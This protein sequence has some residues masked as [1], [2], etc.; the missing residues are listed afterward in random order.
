MAD[1]NEY[2]HF[3]GG[4]PELNEYDDLL[5]QDGKA[6][7]AQL[8]ASMQQA[9]K[10]N[11]DQQAKVLDLSQRTGLPADTVE[12]NQPE[13]EAKAKFEGNDYDKLL[14]DNP[15]LSQHLADRAFASVASDDIENLA[16]VE[17]GFAER[18][19]RNVAARIDTLGANLLDTLQQGQDLLKPISPNVGALVWDDGVIPRY[20]PPSE[21]DQDNSRGVFGALADM[22]HAEAEA[23]EVEQGH[24][25]ETVKQE[26]STGDYTGGMGEVF[27]YAAEQGIV[28][29]PDM[30]GALMSLPVYITSRANEIGDER[31]T[32]KGKE[33]SNILDTLEALPFA[34]GSAM[35]ERIGAG[36]ITGAGKDVAENLGKEALK[37]VIKRASKEGV[38]AGGKEALTEFLQEGIAEYTG[39][40]LGTGAELDIAEAAERGIAGAVAGGVYG[41]VTGGTVAAGRELERAV[42]TQSQFNSIIEAS[43][44][45]ALR[46]RSP[47]LFKQYL[48][49]LAEKSDMDG[50]FI[51]IGKFDELF[52][53][54]EQTAEEVAEQLGVLDEYRE[55]SITSTD[56][57]VPIE[58]YAAEIAPDYHS[59]LAN[60]IKV[61][62]D[63][64]SVS[65]AEAAAQEAEERAQADIERAVAEIESGSSAEAAYSQVLEDIRGQLLGLPQFT[66]QDAVVEAQATQ[67]ASVF[68]TLAQRSN[69]GKPESEH[70][71]AVDLFRRFPVEVQGDIPAILKLTEDRIDEL[72]L[73]LDALENGNLPTDLEVYG[74]SLVEFLRERG[75]VDD[76]GELGSMDADKGLAPFQR[77]LI[78]EE[79]V[80]LDDAALFATEAGYFP[81]LGTDGRADINQLLEAVDAE[82]RG[83]PVYNEQNLDPNLLNRRQ[84]IEQLDE[85]LNRAGLDPAVVDRDQ[86]KG[87]IRGDIS[88]NIASNAESSGLLAQ[89]GQTIR[90][91]FQGRN[92]DNSSTSDLDLNQEFREF[93]RQVQGNEQSTEHQAAEQEILARIV[94][95]WDSIGLQS[96]GGNRLVEQEWASSARYENELGSESAFGK[97]EKVGRAEQEKLIAAAKENNFFLDNDNPLFDGLFAYDNKGGEEHD[98][99]IV[100]EADGKQLV[101]RS[102]NENRF[103]HTSKH[104]PA[105]YLKRLE[106]YNQ[107]FPELQM[108]MIGVRE[109]EDGTAEI[110]TAQQFVKGEEFT[111]QTELDAAMRNEGWFEVGANSH[112]YQHKDTGSVIEDV[113]VG[114]VLHRDGQLYPIDVY[115]AKMPEI[116]ELYQSDAAQPKKLKSES[117]IDKVASG[118]PVTFNFQHNTDSASKHFG[119]PKKGDPFKREFE[120]SGRYVTV[121]SE[122]Q[123]G[124]LPDGFIS[125]EITLNNPLVVRNSG[126]QWK[127]NLSEQYG[128]KTGKELS[129]ALISDGYDGVITTEDGKYISEIVEFTSFDEAKALFQPGDLASSGKRGAILVPKT[130]GEGSASIIK[131][132]QSA[133]LS[134]FLHESGHLYLEMM[135][136]LSSDTDAP[137]GLLN[138]AQAILDWMGLESFDQVKTEHHEMWA[139]TYEQYL[140]E[141]KAP[142]T[143]LARA[144]EKFSAWLK[145]I[146]QQIKKNNLFN[147]NLTPEIRDVMDRLIATDEEIEHARQRNAINPDLLQTD[148][149][150]DKEKEQYIKVWQEAKE[151]DEAKLRNRVM[152]E[153][154][155]QRKKWWQEERER[156]RTEVADQV[157]SRPIYQ[158]LHYLQHKEL[159]NSQLPDDVEV[160]RLSK[161]ILV[162]QWGEEVLKRLPRPYVY[163]RDG[164]VHPDVVAD[165]FGFSSGD[166]LI[167]EL[168]NVRPRQKLINAETDQRMLETYGDML[169]DGTITQEAD[170]SIHNEARA[171]VI[172]LE[173]KVLSRGQGNI[174]TGEKPRDT[175]KTAA[176]QAIAQKKL[177][178]IR[179]NTYLNAEI[180]AAKESAAAAATGDIDNAQLA[181]RRQLLNHYLYREALN[182]RE[183]FDR[184]QRYFSKFNRKGVRKNLDIDYLDQIDAMLERFDFRKAV[185]LK[186]IEK[187]KSLADWIT[188]QHNLGNDVV[189]DPRMENEAYRVH[190]K[191]LPLE[192]LRGLKDTV[193][194]IEHLGRLKNKLLN[195]KEKRE[196]E[197]V[198]GDLTG[199]I[200]DNNKTISEGTDYSPD[201]KG[202]VKEGVGKL[203]AEHTKL[204]FLFRKLDGW[205]GLGEAW[206]QLFKPMVDAENAEHEMMKDVAKQFN[207]IFGKYGTIE[208]SK[209][210][211]TKTFVPELN[212]SFTKD[213]LIAMGLNWGNEGNRQALIEGL[214]ASQSAVEA[215]LKHLDERDWN[216]IQEIWDLINSFW[217][218][219]SNLQRTLTGVS[220]EKVESS[221]FTAPTGQEM[222][223]GYYPLKYDPGRSFLAFRRNQKQDA[224]EMFENNF[225]KPQTRQG[226]LKERVG[227]GGQP[228]LLETSVVTEHLTNIIHDLTHRAAIMDVDRIT[229]DARVREAIERTAGKEMYKQI[230]PW[231][232]A[233]ANDRRVPDNHFE[234]IVGHARTGATVVNMG[235]KITTAIVQPLGY[236]QTVDVVGPKYA[237]IGLQKFFGDGN[238]MKMNERV[239]WAMER[240]QLLQNRMNSYNREVRDVLNKASLKGL[241]YDIDQSFFYLT[242]LMDMAVSV[243][244][245]LGSYEKA[246]NGDAKGVEAG[247]EQQAIDYADSMVRIS[248]SAGSVK[249]LARIQRGS[250]LWRMFTMFYSYFNVLYNLGAERGAQFKAGKKG[251]P[252]LAASAFFLWFA[253]AILS[254][255]IAG[256]GPEDEDEWEA[257]AAEMIAK[258]PFMTVVVLR[259]MVN[260]GFNKAAGRPFDF[261]LTPAADAFAKPVEAIAGITGDLVQEG[262]V[263]RQ[264]FKDT[265]LAVSYWAQLPGRQSWITGE[266]LFDVMTGKENPESVG[267]FLEGVAFT[268]PNR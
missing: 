192:Q 172:E 196:F 236:L 40:R 177:K 110:W 49:G 62:V 46:E 150:T 75:I 175:I 117:D 173:M 216:T 249:D 39:E 261:A 262:E 250:E 3:L 121:A 146:Y 84:A 42:R 97:T 264:T 206:S 95:W 186:A 118:Q 103:G 230:R 87:M 239:S 29:I 234:K 108:R 155:R 240:S 28:S 176:R 81:D 61:R 41:G 151:A 214:Q 21:Y 8:R 142:S 35:L 131:I 104:S 85:L 233:I 78:N 164:G 137:Q 158:A 247:N 190:Y 20:V 252:A 91:F 256:R 99:Y 136:V 80:S 83:S 63:D 179:P 23:F 195:E 133:D 153:I 4:N 243:P 6:K 34:V 77:R 138:D 10:K 259:D 44:N 89:A 36:G 120:P 79:G 207:V 248:Q 205:E 32:N 156:V 242:G 254:E 191:D 109:R 226:H 128:G 119:K 55:A 208:R 74:P 98:A 59:Q 24:T 180:K 38:K 220:P 154:T 218:E 93:Y 90:K 139:E 64:R 5:G 71:T 215:A 213:E 58:V 82:L 126:M 129:K 232:Q 112:K 211:L 18:S 189:I 92:V 223:G 244:T 12:R 257:W 37:D 72:D 260:H 96:R 148:L 212:K 114:N 199:S 152:S 11:P 171:K 115:V 100:G 54:D 160:D 163:Q 102:T 183:E 159:L 225:I 140:M 30:V 268:R 106:E 123:L 70:V 50:V 27:A 187:R 127:Q 193:M 48:Q 178:D 167:Q 170:A 204:E 33:Q 51:P 107:V 122:R 14:K 25:W 237:W 52:Q 147:A 228:V 266:Y 16:T 31:A 26:F 245:W 124:N 202:K 94:Q 184:A 222:Q 181:K 246:M 182:A 56:I 17:H 209:W 210:R 1:R 113:H 105:D 255:L 134:T 15:L 169:N 258:Y 116:K 69:E 198:V 221:S 267:E 149:M 13:I 224:A 265:V 235:W 76:G 67:M 185:S 86:L 174:I 22:G 194:N 143:R 101:I 130:I 73:M 217:P 65:E 251:I 7:N 141:G 125:G 165:L 168:M 203:H 200:Y 157:N 144:F 19:A 60:D 161:D 43:N 145:F 47:E 231:L 135:K 188:T 45:S 111:S 66:G 201:W 253:P 68:H 227:S 263:D 238:P 53:S 219:I 166:Q 57:I 229:K 88:V 197:Q 2:D 241:R 162:D 132:G 9:S